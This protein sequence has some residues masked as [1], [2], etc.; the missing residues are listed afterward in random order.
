[1]VLSVLLPVYLGTQSEELQACLDS[2]CDQTYHANEI[3]LVKDGPLHPNTES[4]IVEYSST[5]PLKLLTFRDNRGIGPALQDALPLCRYPL[6]ARV[7]SDDRCLPRRFEIQMDFLKNNPTISVVGGQM[8]ELYSF[9]GCVEEA[10]RLGPTDPSTLNRYAKFRNPMNHPTVMF[11]KHDVLKCGGYEECHLFEDYLLW[12]KMLVSGY[13]LANISDVLVETDINDDYFRRRGGIDYLKDEV[14][15]CSHLVQLGFFSLVD[16][17]LFLSTRAPIRLMP[18]YA[19]QHFY[20]LSLRRRRKQ[21]P[22]G[23]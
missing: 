17:I 10:I 18:R 2:L 3:L 21:R 16:S 22:D 5:L 9:R 13:T 12:A 14:T 11:R 19:R 23:T 8:R 6:V 4:I 20:R 7:D 15:L 1:M